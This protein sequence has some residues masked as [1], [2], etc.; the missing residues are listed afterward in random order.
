MER[1]GSGLQ[2]EDRSR[3][4]RVA[5]SK[6][7]LDVDFEKLGRERIDTP[8]QA[9][10]SSP[11]LTGSQA[12]QDETGYRENCCHTELGHCVRQRR[13]CLFAA[14]ERTQDACCGARDCQALGLRVVVER[15]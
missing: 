7:N 3:C 14:L 4:R 13:S 8:C 11:P 5:R 2:A 10:H 12:A 9:L 15:R 6:G 1:E